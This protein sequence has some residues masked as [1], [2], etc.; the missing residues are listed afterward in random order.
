MAR[1]SNY[2]IIF[3]LGE[4]QDSS[5]IGNI[6]STQSVFAQTITKC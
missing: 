1:R 3:R 4:I 2:E 6:Q 5:D